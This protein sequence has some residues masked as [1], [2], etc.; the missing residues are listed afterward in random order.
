[1]EVRKRHKNFFV[2]YSSNKL[3][4]FLLRWNEE[5]QLRR[6][7]L[8][9]QTGPG[10]MLQCSGQ[11]TVHE[12]RGGGGV[13]WGRGLFLTGHN[14]EKRARGIP[15]DADASPGGFHGNRGPEGTRRRGGRRR[16]CPEGRLDVSKTVTGRRET[17]NE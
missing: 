2:C 6:Q 16:L 11:R 7:T 5:P 14:D 4:R 1:M 15:Q 9:L 13:R 10:F 8:N 3:N 12:T 17:V